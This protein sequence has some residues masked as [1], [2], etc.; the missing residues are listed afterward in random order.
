MCASA[1]NVVGESV[2]GVAL[3]LVCAVSQKRLRCRC[4]VGTA[5]LIND[6][7]KTK[8]FAQKIPRNH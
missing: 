5:L 8:K 2:E 6:L 3:S 4:C 7:Q 1:F